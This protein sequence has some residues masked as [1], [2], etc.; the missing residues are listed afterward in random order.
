MKKSVPEAPPITV[1]LVEDYAPFRNTVSKLINS[2]PGLSCTHLFATGEDALRSLGTQAK[3]GVILLDVGLP[4]MNGIEFLM[5]VRDAAPDARVVIL[6]AFEDEE[7]LFR[8]ICSGASGYLLKT[9]KSDEI[10]AAIREAHAGGALMTPSIAKRV[11]EMFSRMAPAKTDYGLSDRE[12]LVLEKMVGGLT[13]KEIAAVLDM[14]FHT[15]D[16]ALRSIY[17]KLEVNT[18]TGAVAKAL[19]EKLV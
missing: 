10:I 17:S 19:K 6:T 11:F 4:G 9:A 15:V 16:A 1:W 8:A 7:K 13:K 14:N 5:K 12:K 2:T 3:P 18:R